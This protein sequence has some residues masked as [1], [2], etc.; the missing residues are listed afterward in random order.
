MEVTMNILLTRKA[1]DDF[2]LVEQANDGCQHA[3]TLLMERHHGAIY[4][5][6]Y[7]MT[8]D[9]EDA[10]DLTLEA[11]GKAFTRLRTYVPTYAFSTWLYKI[12]VNNCIDFVRKKRLNVLSIDE[13]IDTE[14]DADF[15]NT[16][17]AG[18]PDPEETVIRQQR[19]KLMRQLLTHLGDK[20]RLM[21]ELRYFE[22]LSYE[23]ISQELN[24]PLGTVKAQL[25]RAKEL[26][27]EL[28]QQPGAGAFIDW[29]VSRKAG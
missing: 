17:R 28:L 18:C 14:S 25:F 19:N 20:Y 10:N 4:R 21:I 27:Y 3:Y 23:E 8:N 26:L 29:S 5:L 16:L 1:Q 15:T 13:P 11:F 7:R 9:R 12:A 6:M 24:I 2:C 22:E